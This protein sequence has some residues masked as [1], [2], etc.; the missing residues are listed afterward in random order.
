MHL[1]MCLYISSF[2]WECQ[3]QE[4]RT[5]FPWGTYFEEVSHDRKS[6]LWISQ[7]LIEFPLLFVIWPWTTSFNCSA[8]LFSSVKLG[9]R[10]YECTL[11]WG[12][13]GKGPTARRYSM[14]AA[15]DWGYLMIHELA[16]IYVCVSLCHISG[17]VSTVLY[18]KQ[19]YKSC[20]HQHQPWGRCSTCKMKS[21]ISVLSHLWHLKTLIQRQS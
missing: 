13:V 8:S 9:N 18:W 12:S 5:P 17:C 11:T 14:D 21:S 6:N 3:F 16:D 20:K 2:P 19:S 15:M 10:V 4:S 1:I 7:N